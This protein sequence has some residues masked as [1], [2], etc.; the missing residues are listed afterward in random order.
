MKAR[1]FAEMA[2][3]DTQFTKA[4][5]EYFDASMETELDK[6]WKSI[7]SKFTKLSKRK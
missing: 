1:P 3:S 7:E 2:A 4:L 5:N 6:Q